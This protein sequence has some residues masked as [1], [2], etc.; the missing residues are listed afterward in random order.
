MWACNLKFHINKTSLEKG[1]L[2]RFAEAVENFCAKIE[3]WVFHKVFQQPPIIFQSF[4][5]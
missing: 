3:L 1:Q 4:S 2:V 5:S